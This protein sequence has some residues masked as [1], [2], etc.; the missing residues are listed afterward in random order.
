[1]SGRLHSITVSG[2]PYLYGTMS[3]SEMRIWVDKQSR[4]NRVSESGVKLEPLAS[5]ESGCKDSVTTNSYI[6]DR[7]GIEQR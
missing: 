2:G 3:K 7:S 1:M 6:I 4:R 5:T